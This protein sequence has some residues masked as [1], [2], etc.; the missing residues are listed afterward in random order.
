MPA[1][2][3]NGIYGGGEEVLNTLR[4]SVIGMG[5]LKLS[6]GNLKS[7]QIETLIKLYVLKWKAKK[8]WFEQ[9][10]G[11]KSKTLTKA[12][13]SSEIVNIQKTIIPIDAS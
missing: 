11:K 8:I 10:K 13:K 9:M 4:L 3:Q 5:K 6:Q 2:Q 7:K 12:K 1:P